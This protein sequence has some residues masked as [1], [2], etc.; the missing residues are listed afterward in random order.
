MARVVTRFVLSI[1]T[2]ADFEGVRTSE[3]VLDCPR[4]FDDLAVQIILT[5]LNVERIK[6]NRARGVTAAGFSS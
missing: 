5:T 2:E 6:A 4:D 1:T 3:L